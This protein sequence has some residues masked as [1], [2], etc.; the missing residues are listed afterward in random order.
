MVLHTRKVL[1]RF[2]T[3]WLWVCGVAMEGW[4]IADIACV[5]LMILASDRIGGCLN[6]SFI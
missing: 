6:L 2:M 3:W 5:C 1:E 4:V